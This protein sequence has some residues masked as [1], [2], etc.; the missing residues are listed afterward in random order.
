[1]A[2]AVDTWAQ[3]QNAPGVVTAAAESAVVVTPSDT[4]DLTNASRGIYVGGT[5]TLTAIM[6]DGTTCL[7][8]GIPAGTILP[9][10]ATRVK[11]TGTT[12]TLIVALS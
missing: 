5:G 11:A 4:V 1:M 3:M 8:S 2:A 12:A 7:F 10:R 6:L 9:I